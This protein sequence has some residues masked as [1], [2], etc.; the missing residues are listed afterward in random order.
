MFVSGELD[1][2]P[3]HVLVNH[4]PS[5]SG[6]EST[7]APMRNHAASLCKNIVDS[8]TAID[9]NA[10]VIVMGD[11]NDD[12]VSPSVKKVLKAKSKKETVKKGEMFNPMY[13]YFKKGI[14]TNAY[15]DAWSNFDQLI[16]TKGLL[17]DENGFRFL[18][19]KIF[20][21]PY[22]LQKTGQYKGYPKRAYSFSVYAGGYSDHFPVYSILVKPTGDSNSDSKE[23]NSK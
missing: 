19:A 20:R 8:L 21:K 10:K 3:I 13:A 12:P 18:A 17:D 14:G 22:M 7:T 6:G 16:F 4:W 5:R 1:G 2:E 9:P 15:R 23:P 11:L